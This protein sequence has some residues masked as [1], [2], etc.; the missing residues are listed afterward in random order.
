M[1]S[2]LYSDEACSEQSSN[3]Y[4]TTASIGDCQP[5]P[6]PA[7]GLP[8]FLRY[9]T[10]CSEAPLFHCK[11]FADAGVGIKIETSSPSPGP[12][13]PKNDMPAGTTT[14]VSTV[15]PTTTT[16]L[17]EPTSR[18]SRMKIGGVGQIVTVLVGGWFGLL[19][20]E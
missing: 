4:T 6:N 11:D 15:A 2:E 1:V 12:T 10:T 14:Q 3:M 7:L 18:A 5:P 17:Q 9:K 8:D 20:R 16:P 13:V 19:L